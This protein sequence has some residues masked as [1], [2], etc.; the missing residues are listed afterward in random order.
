M[1]NP[2]VAP[3]LEPLHSPA[4][5]ASGSI[6]NPIDAAIFINVRLNVVKVIPFEN[7]VVTNMTMALSK[8]KNWELSSLDWQ[9]DS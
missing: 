2:M 4:L 1:T 5:A 6:T 9:D 7:D 8:K 3:L